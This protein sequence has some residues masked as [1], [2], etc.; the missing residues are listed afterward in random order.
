[1]TLT[2]NKCL[3]YDLFTDIHVTTGI[4]CNNPNCEI[5][6]HKTDINYLYKQICDVLDTAS[7]KYIPSSKIDY[8]RE[9]IVPCYNEHVK[10][11]HAIA[12]HNFVMWRVLAN[13]DLEKF[14]F[15]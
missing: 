6:S 2:N 8:Y 14:V 12:R 9:H 11:L 3:T 5:S 7:K 1:M 13:L 15:Q 4:K 10:E